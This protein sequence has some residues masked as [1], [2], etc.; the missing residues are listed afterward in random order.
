MEQL[1]ELIGARDYRVFLN[2]RNEL[3]RA[4]NMKTGPPPR[5]EAIRLMSENPNLVRRPILVR[6]RQVVLGY[7][8]EE[9]AKVSRRGRPAESG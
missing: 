5:E 1:E 4:R 3:Y 7:E 2:P 6:G 9:M 8:P